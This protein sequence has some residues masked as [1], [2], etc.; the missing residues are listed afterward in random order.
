MLAPTPRG[1]FVFTVKRYRR[2]KLDG[3]TC[4][5][6]QLDAESPRAIELFVKGQ[7]V[8]VVDIA[9]EDS[10]FVENVAGR[11]VHAVRPPRD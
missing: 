2:G 11:T 10:L 7:A 6:F 1:L 4:D 3:W 5:S 8:T 9:P